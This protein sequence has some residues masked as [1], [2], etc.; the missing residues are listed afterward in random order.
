MTRDVIEKYI[1]QHRELEQGPAQ[2][3]LKLR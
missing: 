3:D 2:L 1:V